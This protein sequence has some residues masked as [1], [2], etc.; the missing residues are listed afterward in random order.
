[1]GANNT[2]NPVFAELQK[3]KSQGQS[4]GLTG[5]RPSPSTS[6]PAAKFSSEIPTG[7]TGKEG[8]YFDVGKAN[9][10]NNAYKEILGRQPSSNELQSLPRDQQGLQTIEALRSSLQSQKNSSEIPRYATQERDDYFDVGKAAAMQKAQT[11]V[12]R[13]RQQEEQMRRRSPFFR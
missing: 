7:Q 10:I 9:A 6:A 13:R 3:A 11:D 1:M 12:M 5:I 8:D 2:S 4:V